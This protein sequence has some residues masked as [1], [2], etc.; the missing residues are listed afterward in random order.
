M[1]PYEMITI[2]N[3]S[4]RSFEEIISEYN[5]L[6][7]IIWELEFNLHEAGEEY[8]SLFE[9]YEKITDKLYG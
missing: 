4:K 2:A 7:E 1:K 6:I 9:E 3:A 5:N 8:D